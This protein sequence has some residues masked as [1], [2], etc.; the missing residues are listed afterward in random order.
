VGLRTR[1]RIGVATDWRRKYAECTDPWRGLMRDAPWRVH[2]YAGRGVRGVLPVRSD[3]WFEVGQFLR[4]L[5]DQKLLPAAVEC[6]R[7]LLE[8]H[9]TAS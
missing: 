2:L 1:T 9:G 4:K 3:P 6:M 5:G 7:L 8:R